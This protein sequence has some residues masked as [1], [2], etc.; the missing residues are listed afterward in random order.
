M[1]DWRRYVRDRLPALDIS[2][3]REIEIVDELAL[4]LEAAYDAARSN[5]ATDSEARGAAAREVPDWATL[6]STLSRIERAARSP[7]GRRSTETTVIGISRGRYMAGLSQDVRYA[8]RALVRAPGFAAVAIATLALGIGATTIIFSLVDGILLKPLP[9]ADPSRVVLGRELTSSGQEFSVSWPNFVDWRERA[10]SFEKLAVWRGLPANLTGIDR[11]RRL[12]IRQVSWNLFDTLGVRP[13]VGRGLTE[14][15]DQ[16]GVERVGLVSYGFW[17]RELGGDHRAIGRRIT[18]DEAPVTVVGVLP[19]DFTIARQEDVFLPFGNFL[20]PGSFL[21]MRGNHNGLSAVGRLAPDAT[22]ESARAELATIAAQLAAE[23]P[24]T[25]SGQS[26][27]AY[28]LIEGLVSD[29][30]PMLSV[31]LGA[32]L[33]MLL[34]ACANLANLMLARSSGRAQELA[35]RRALGAAGWRIARQ[36][37]TESV[38]IGI[39]GGIAGALLAWLGFEAVVALLPSDQPRIHTVALDTRVLAVAALLSIVTGLVFGLLPAVRSATGRSLSL[40]RSARVTGAPSSRNTTRKLLVLAEVALALVL[41]AGAGLMVRT[42]SNLLTIDLGFK[43]DRLI[44]A[45]VSLPAPRYTPEARRAFYDAII[46]RVRAIPGVA[47]AALTNSL[48]VQGSNWNSV[49]IVNDQPVPAR[50]DLPSAAFT[51]VTPRYHEVMGVALIQGRLLHPSDGPGSTMVAVVN[52]SLAKRFWPNG[53]AIGQRVKQGWPEDKTDWFEIVGVVRDVKTAGV[54]RPAALQVYLPLAQ[55]TASAV[56][57][58]ARTRVEPA[59]LATSL[60]AAVQQVDP[61]LP[62]YDIRTLD[63]VIGLVV[64]QQRLTMILLLGFAALAL[65]IAAIGVFGVTACA[66]SQRTHEL[67][68]RMALGA[69][70][71]EVVRLVLRHEL[72]ACAGGIVIGIAGALALSS[73]LETL[74]YGVAPRD[75]GTLAIV[76]LVLIATTAL[77]GYLPARRATRI[78]PVSALRIE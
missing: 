57:L 50:A 46:E 34:I 40:L 14:A 41:L 77:A 43:P 62:V 56:A 58:V 22:V 9:I 21:L 12:M 75:A 39:C 20:N 8:L 19:A 70:R 26:A 76:S 54:D 11:P 10:K 4:Q 28:P 3:E 32:V 7:G 25:N 48:P 44:S 59:S 74:V 23:H 15:D 78:D 63:D 45:Q 42:M 17:Q 69:T 30:R 6:A 55:R 18:L 24:D 71:G 53:N 51:P 33:T 38:L 13:I 16:P 65:L 72:I 66:V 52:E 5:G 36:L 47:D 29:A 60:E 49:F 37:L 35:V 67:G 31:L 73:L 64:G 2:P 1:N 68:V 61:S 27:T